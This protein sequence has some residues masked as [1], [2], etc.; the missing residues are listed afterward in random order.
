M[1][2]LT[3]QARAWSRSPLFWIVLL[4]AALRIIAIGWGLPA[5]DGWDDDGI[6]PRDIVVGVIETYTPGHYYIYP[7]LQFI[8][9]TVLT[10]PV[11]IVALINAHSLHPQDIIAA[12]TQVRY[13]TVF[14]IV[15]RMVDWAMSLATIV[16]VFRLTE[17]IAPS[18]SA[19]PRP[20]CGHLPRQHAAH[21]RGREGRC[22]GYFAAAAC[23]LSATL[24]YYGHVT[25]LDTAYLFWTVWSLWFWVRV[26]TEHRTDL[27]RWGMLSAVAAVATK[28]QAYAVFL[29]AIPLTLAAWFAADPW[30]RQNWRKIAVALLVWG[31]VAGLALLLIDGAVTN[32][33]G[34]AHR[35]DFLIGPASRD[36][37]YYSADW[38]GRFALLRDMWG[39][40]PRSYPLA[41]L[42][43]GV[44]GL[45]FQFQQGRGNGARWAAG[46][47]PFFAILSFTLAFNFTV[48][49]SEDRFVLP[50]WLFAS[51]YIG[52]ACAQLAFA[53]RPALRYATRLILAPLA[54]YAFYECAAV[55]AAFI[56][57]PRYEAEAWLA[58][59]VKP[60]DTL[61]IYGQNCFL[62]RLPAGAAM[63][64]VDSKPL[65]PRNPQLDVT[66]ISQPFEAI[67]QRNPKFILIPE[68]WVRPYLLSPDAP[69]PPG[70]IYSVR[71]LQTFARSGA[72]AYFHQ[73]YDGRLPYRLV[74][75]SVYDPGIWPMVRLHESL[76]ETIQI[77]ERV[78]G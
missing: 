36:Y 70:Q 4:A 42:T 22:A 77:F 37:A 66:E 16:F 63:T 7:P 29:I 45:F 11:S 68:I 3:D 32:P 13:M 1:G 69:L 73:L 61:E 6:A 2:T 47:L 52:I 55:D 23:A 19:G 5:S 25:N 27:I 24:T 67:A 12:F 41:A 53:T 35:L 39:T 65:L 9:L 34:F 15:A 20:S 28:D 59:H 40:F 71:Q 46:L 51:V 14:A 57:D 75:Q 38:R 21:A 43:F 72:R 33:T 49:R 48:L 62:P 56:N 17:V 50:Q 74:H 18:P 31:S 60:G 76:G 26:I 58:T 10:L 30:P 8:I 64:R 78:S 54:L 44:L